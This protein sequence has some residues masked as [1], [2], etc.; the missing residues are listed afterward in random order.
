MSK[1]KRFATLK[2]DDKTIELPILSGSEGPDAVDVT[3]L[4][5]ETGIFTYD[6]GFM[7]TASCSSSI[8]YIDGNAGILKYR[9]FHIEEL[10]EKSNFPEVAYL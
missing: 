5:T 2:F 8:T 9:G 1:N 4:Y 3:K 10:A 6:P 7:S